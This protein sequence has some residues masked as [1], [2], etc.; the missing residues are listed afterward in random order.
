MVEALKSDEA[1]RESVGQVFA[2]LVSLH[3]T[4]MPFEGDTLAALQAAVDVWATHHSPND[5]RF[6]A[7]VPP[8]AA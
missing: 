1:L 6:V 5:P 7:A 3:A 8:Q 4:E 2:D